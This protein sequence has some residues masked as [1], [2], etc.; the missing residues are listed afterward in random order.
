MPRSAVSLVRLMPPSENATPDAEL[1]RALVVAR[2]EEVFAEIVRRHGPMVLAAC[3][4]V[5][6]HADDADDAFQAV[7][8][9]LARKA[10]TIRGAN[11]AGWLYAVAVRTARGT[12]HARPPPEARDGCGERPA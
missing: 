1:L 11:L 4:R 3:R 12:D 10:T 7:F 9:V 8:L 2:G 6:G 5:L